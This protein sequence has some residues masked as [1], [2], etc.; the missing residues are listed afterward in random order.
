M[1]INKQSPWFLVF[2]A[3]TGVTVY[4]IVLLVQP[5]DITERLI[6]GRNDFMQ[7][8]AGGRLAGT[9]DLYST[10]AMYTIQRE[11]VGVRSDTMA[12]H[13]RLPFYACLLHPLALLPYRAAY[14]TF[15]AF[16]LLCF[17]VFLWL[18][19]P[20]S[21][22]LAAFASLSIPLFASLQNGQDSTVVLMLAAVSVILVRQHR[23]FLAGMVLTLCTIKF[24][25]FVLIP[26]ML[27]AQRRW[28]V[29]QG[30]LAG[31]AILLAVSFACGGVAWPRAYAQAIGD[32][33]MH[34]NPDFMPNIHGLASMLGRAGPIVELA[35]SLVVATAVFY[36]ARKTPDYELAFGFA[37][38]GS[39]LDSRHSGTHDCIVLLLPL[40][41]L[42]AKPFSKRVRE[43]TEMAASPIPYFFLLA[44]APLSAAMPCLLMAILA[45][46][47]FAVRRAAESSAADS[48]RGLPSSAPF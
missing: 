17:F 26:L 2:L 10:S 32:P 27:I 40:A 43:L 35:L 21:R 19:V 5:R 39:L 38:V 25:L 4:L 47:L 18:F 8:Y 12:H 13:S 11:V 41:I 31:G 36:L 44:G 29:L 45:A 1:P 33:I 28:R 34:L 14:Y 42:L 9:S 22:A 23:D 3:I 48:W 7:L 24:N 16:S 46:A 20:E 30:G 6:L 37:I 15:Q